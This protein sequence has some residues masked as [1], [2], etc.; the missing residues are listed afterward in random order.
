M[1]V[2][3]AYQK[4]QRTWQQMQ[5]Q[6]QSRDGHSNKKEKTHEN[7]KE[8]THEDEEGEEFSFI[9][10]VG[11]IVR[12]IILTTLEFAVEALCIF[13]KVLLRALGLIG[14]E[15]SVIRKL[16]VSLVLIVGVMAFNLIYRVYDGI[17]K[18]IEAWKK[19]LRLH[20]PAEKAE[21]KQRKKK[22]KVAENKGEEDVVWWRKKS[23]TTKNNREE[24]VGWW[25][26]R[27]PKTTKKENKGVGDVR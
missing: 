24:D 7:K 18:R 1:K 20:T 19:K 16:T 26:R 3:Q 6:M 21:R 11:F 17:S 5:Q 23:K 27:K 9:R 12:G 14:P 22:P 13:C 8:K 15:S 4:P 25:W 2:R 10:A